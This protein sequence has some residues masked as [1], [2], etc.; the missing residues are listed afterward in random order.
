MKKKRGIKNELHF[1]QGRA[2]P[3]WQR[4]GGGTV[5]AAAWALGGLCNSGQQAARSGA[6]CDG[7]A[8]L[9]APPSQFESIERPARRQVCRQNGSA[10]FDSESKCGSLSIVSREKRTAYRVRFYLSEQVVGMARP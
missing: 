2:E 7:Q 1:V 10:C 6:L 5:L 9:T 8:H 3:V 4:G